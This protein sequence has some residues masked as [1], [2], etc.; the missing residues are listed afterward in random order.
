MRSKNNS[1]RSQGPAFET[2]E[3]RRLMSASLS[4]G[5]AELTTSGDGSIMGGFGQLRPDVIGSPVAGQQ[6]AVGAPIV[7]MQQQQW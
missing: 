2:L 3:E 4:S 1:F 7:G 5:G 6:V